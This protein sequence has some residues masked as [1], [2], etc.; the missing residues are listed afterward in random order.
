MPT[1]QTVTEP[2]SH[3]LFILYL[4]GNHTLFG[5]KLY[6]IWKFSS[7]NTGYDLRCLK[8]TLNPNNQQPTKHL[9]LFDHQVNICGAVRSSACG[10][11][12]EREASVC[13]GG[14]G[15]G[16]VSDKLELSDDG[17]LQLKYEG[18]RLS[19]GTTYEGGSNRTNKIDGAEVGFGCPTMQYSN[20]DVLQQ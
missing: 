7:G 20:Q 9:I 2:A 11:I 17:Q 6:F 19:N 4:E 14:Q 10:K 15:L 5:E 16:I 3:T 12:G 18:T 13:D 8:K 1:P